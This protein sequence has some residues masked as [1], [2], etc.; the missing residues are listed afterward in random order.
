VLF[1][2]GFGCARDIEVRYPQKVAGPSGTITVVLTEPVDNVAVTVNGELVTHSRKTGRVRVTN[3]DIGTVDVAVAAGLNDKQ[4]RVWLNTDQEITLP[5]AAAPT[6]VTGG[7]VTTG[8]S[9]ALALAAL[10]LL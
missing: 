4:F 10:L 5:V 3:V 6:P 9:A 1:L 7:W 8:I 2:A